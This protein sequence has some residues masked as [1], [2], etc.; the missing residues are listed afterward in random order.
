MRNHRRKQYI[1]AAIALLI[2]FF[3]TPIHAAPFSQGNTP[4]ELAA[5]LL[6]RLSPAE[7]V[8][9]LFL[10]TFKGSDIGPKT[11]IYDLI[12]KHYIGGVVLSNE[13]D[14]F[15]TSNK[16]IQDTHKLINQLQYNRLSASQ[17]NELEH[18]IDGIFLPKYIP[19]FVGISQEGDGA[20]YDQMLSGLTTLPSQLSIGATWDPKF[21][22]QAGV[23]AGD[24]LST[25]G[26]NLLFGP[27]LDV[28][29]TP[30]S[31]GEGDLNVRVFSGDPFWVGEM[32]SAYIAGIHEGSNN[33][34][35]V[36][37]THFPGL[38]SAD[39]IPIEEVATVRKS[40]EQLKQIELAPFFA[41][42]G[43]ASSQ[44]NQVDAL[45]TSHIRYQGL[46]GNIRSTTRP[47]SFD[48]Q[49]LDLL[50]DL[51][52]LENWRSNGG[53]MISDDLGSPAVRRFHD[54]TEATFN[55]QRLALDA[56][57]AGND[58]LFV[59]NFIATDDPDTFTTV[60]RTLDFFTKKYNEDTIF[61]Q[62]VNASVLRILTLK[63]RIYDTFTAFSITPPGS[64]DN[65]GSPEA[66]QVTHEIAQRSATLISPP[67]NELDN[68]FPSAP[69]RIDRIVFITDNYLT[70]QC[71]NCTPIPALGTLALE[72][73]V[74][75]LYGPDTGRQTS[76]YY[77]DSYSFEQLIDT[78][79]KKE[80]TQEIEADL[81]NAQWLVFTT[82]NIDPERPASQALHRFLAERQDLTREKNIIVFA[83]NAPYYL[84]ATEIS[85][86]TAYFGIF[87]K[88]EP[89]INV[90]ARLLYKE[91]LNPPGSL[92]V[93]VPGIGYK[94][95]EATSPSSE[96]II[97]LKIDID[98]LEIPYETL[99]PENDLIRE[100]R[101]GDT[102]SL[103]T[104]III[105]KNGNTVPDGTP[106]Q[107]I[108]TI[109]A[110]ES[111]IVSTTT[112][113]GTATAQYEFMQ[114]GTIGIQAKS[115]S[116]SSN[117]L[118]FEIPSSENEYFPTVVPTELP[119]II[120]SPTATEPSINTQIE[121]P[122]NALSHLT[123]W[124][125]S[126]LIIS[127][128]VSA[129]VFT[130]ARIGQVRL[131][132]RWGL[133]AMIAGLLSYSYTSLALLESSLAGITSGNWMI[134]TLTCIGSLIGWGISAIILKNKD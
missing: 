122:R 87:S 101:L 72:K 89:F 93:S 117:E 99:F 114:P 48:Q 80:N 58:I 118:L 30:R 59:N 124:L 31:E 49:A 76:Q 7:R 69:N 127:G 115:V 86:L 119:I 5:D 79:D 68:A 92:P 11:Q 15:S 57:L 53:V 121:S 50:M 29:E 55:A 10:V 20:P 27:S 6:A 35:A 24:E 8:G 82:L 70:Q 110:N 56:F 129:A 88:T 51:P 9:Q 1:L 41:V 45:L 105:D 126:L 42:T 98:E 104:G 95:I 61:A 23:I 38:G 47:I 84:D 97:N 32:G 112:N 18:N 22:N 37:G 113:S 2:I 71:S 83:A 21:A 133:F 130:G 125:I 74:L 75:N 19:L 123:D 128:V 52:P 107:F 25:L 33:R 66:K 102:I 39:H 132:V 120:P 100:Y 40:L 54:P 111:L 91:L 131:G 3:H 109:N 4:E 106:V 46:Q 64:L 108:I 44:E 26:V 77:L 13:N 134:F 12:T 63:F 17:L 65:I 43:Y 36:V 16:I 85:K 73:A 67:F 96:Q 103:S 81:R 60:T 62:R 34:I 116:A 78:I 94:L 90:A 14:N 28:L